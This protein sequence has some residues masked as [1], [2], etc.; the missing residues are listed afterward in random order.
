MIRPSATTSL[1]YDVGTYTFDLKQSVGPGEYSLTTPAPHCMPCFATDARMNNGTTGGSECSDG[2]LVDVESEL[3]NRSRRATNCPTGKYLPTKPC[4]LK[5]YPSCDRWTLPAEDTRLNNPPC[6]LRGTGWNRWEWLCQDP[7]DRALVPFDF[8]V[9]TSIVVKDNHRPVLPRPLNQ[10]EA[11]PAGKGM[12][13]ERGAPEWIPP[14]CEPS[15]KGD[16]SL[17]IVHWR[18][19]SEVSAVAPKA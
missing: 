7:Q 3:H 11:L 18:T 17:P 4:P 12:P 16:D 15:W 10:A 6:T 2:P 19:C 13:P 5:N 1:R 14:R 9:D 8:N